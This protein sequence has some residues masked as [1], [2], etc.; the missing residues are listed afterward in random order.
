MDRFLNFDNRQPE[1]VSVVISGVVTDP[2]GMNVRVKF[3]DSKSDCYRD[4]RLPSFV[5]N[6]DDDASR[7][8]ALPEKFN[9]VCNGGEIRAAITKRA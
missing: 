7:H 6:D 5:T 1:V 2:T 4:I 9:I 8:M 3:G